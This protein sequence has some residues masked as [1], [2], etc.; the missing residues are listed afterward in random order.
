[1]S[2]KKT[3]LFVEDDINL[4]LLLKKFLEEAG[5][6]IVHFADGEEAYKMLNGNIN[7]FELCILDYMLPGNDGYILAA[8]IKK[9]KKDLPIVFLT[10]RSMKEDKIRCFNIGIDDYITK[11]FDEEELLCRIKVILRRNYTEDISQDIFHIGKYLFDYPN[12]T[13]SINNSARRITQK[14]CEVLKLLC[15]N[16]NRLLKKNEIL[17]KAWGQ[18]DYF[19][20]RSLD[21][22]IT[23]IRKYLQNDTTVSIENVHGVGFILNDLREKN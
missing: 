10:A 6:N 23:K 9:M 2:N 3:I 12:Q 20:G 15:L 7:L 5:F 11:P 14:E 18:S 13:I 19:L 22:F 21:V 16:K 4:T 17:L 8:E 1:M